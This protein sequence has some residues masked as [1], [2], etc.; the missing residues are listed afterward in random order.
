MNSEFK[1]SS[2]IFLAAF[3]FITGCSTGRQPYRQTPQTVAA[4]N[5]PP[6]LGFIA[7]IP[8]LK[9]VSMK[10]SESKFLAI[11]HK[12]KLDYEQGEIADETIYYVQPQA[13]VLVLFMFRNGKCAGVQRLSN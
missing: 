8:S 4:Q 13:H 5:P 2:F 9:G 7:D 3:L 1:K 6:E 12:Q 10:M 11:L